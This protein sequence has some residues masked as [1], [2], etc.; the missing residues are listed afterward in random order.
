[1]GAQKKASVMLAT[2]RCGK[3][4]GLLPLSGRK[5]SKNRRHLSL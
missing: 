2:K 5:N 1:M 3:T 4:I